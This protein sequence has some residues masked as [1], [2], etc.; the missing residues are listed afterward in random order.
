MRKFKMVQKV[1]KWM[2]VV[3]LM[4]WGSWPEKPALG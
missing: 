4:G 3:T 2:T 1:P